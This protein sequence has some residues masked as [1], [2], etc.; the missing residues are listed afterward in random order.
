MLRGQLTTL[1]NVEMALLLSETRETNGGLTTTTMLFRQLDRHSLNDFLV[2]TL[3]GR[4]EHAITID[5]N[6]TKLVIVFQK[7][8]QWLRFKT[9][10]ASVAE[11]V[12]GAERLK[13]MLDLLFSVSVLLQNDTTKDDKSISWDVF[14]KLQPLSGRS[15]RRNDR[16]ACLTRLDVFSACQF[17]CQQLHVLVKRITGWNVQRH[18]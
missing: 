17:R 10:L 14:V 7:R 2:V 6:E 11:H 16:L 8:K 9:I 1:D 4:E 13:G 12:N 18:E 3:E 15:N 5:D